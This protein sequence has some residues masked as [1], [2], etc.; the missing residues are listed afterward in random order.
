MVSFASSRIRVFTT[1]PVAFSLL[2]QVSYALS[3]LL[4]RNVQARAPL[5]GSSRSAAVCAALRS[6][7]S[8]FSCILLSPPSIVCG[9][10]A[11]CILIAQVT[12]AGYELFAA[13]R[14]QSQGQFSGTLAPTNATNPEALAFAIATGVS[15]RLGV[16]ISAVQARARAF[17]IANSPMLSCMWAAEL[18]VVCSACRLARRLWRR[19]RL[20][21]RRRRQGPWRCGTHARSSSRPPA[22]LCRPWPLRHLRLRHLRRR[23]MRA[24]LACPLPGPWRCRSSS[25]SAATPAWQRKPTVRCTLRAR[26]A[27]APAA[28]RAQPPLLPAAAR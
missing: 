15:E 17:H 10:A 1:L 2:A 13:V 9:P 6:E 8:A 26:S 28:P 23:V 3:A 14:F 12:I 5:T 19:R 27:L 4:G 7:L 22:P 18:T 20:P 24:P 16:Q 25:L 11:L 21:R